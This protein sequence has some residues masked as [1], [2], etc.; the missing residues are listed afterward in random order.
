MLSSKNCTSFFEVLLL[1][2]LL[3]LL[4]LL[5]LLLLLLR[6]DGAGDVP[7]NAPPAAP[8]GPVTIPPGPWGRPSIASEPHTLPKAPPSVTSS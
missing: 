5:L 1:L 8:T 3:L 6:E 4:R 7:V 2:L